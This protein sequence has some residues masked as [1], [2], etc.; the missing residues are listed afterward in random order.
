MTPGCT[1]KPRRS[2][3]MSEERRKAMKTR[4]VA[5]G[6]LEGAEGDAKFI[7]GNY[8]TAVITECNCYDRTRWYV[9]SDSMPKSRRHDPKKHREIKRLAP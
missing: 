7:A 3:G 9:G 6:S 2:E 5:F 8:G 4:S 1:G